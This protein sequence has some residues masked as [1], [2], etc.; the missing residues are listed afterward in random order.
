MPKVYITEQEKY[1]TNLVALIYGAM[2]AQKK[3]QGELAKVVGVHQTAISLKLRNKSFKY[4]DLVEIFD[5]LGL[6]DQ[7]ILSVMRKGRV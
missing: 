7:Q 2:K 3:T 4:E 6:S 1:K 5:Y